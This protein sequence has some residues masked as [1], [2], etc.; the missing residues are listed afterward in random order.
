MHPKMPKTERE[1]TLQLSK[2]LYEMHP[3]IKGIGM[4]SPKGKPELKTRD[5]AQINAW[6]DAGVP[7][8]MYGIGFKRK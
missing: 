2:L 5:V 1:F 4:V 7:L 8:V 3:K 6:Y